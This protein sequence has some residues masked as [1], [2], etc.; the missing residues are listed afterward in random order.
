MWLVVLTSYVT[1]VFSLVAIAVMDG[2]KVTWSKWDRKDFIYCR[3]RGDISLNLLTEKNL[4]IPQSA[5][6]DTGEDYFPATSIQTKKAWILYVF[7]IS[8]AIYNIFHTRKFNKLHKGLLHIHV[9]YHT[10]CN[11]SSISIILILFP[12]IQPRWRWWHY[13]VLNK[14]I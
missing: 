4:W 7:K 12:M 9:T 11:P 1:A 6:M 2:S 10:F 3:S 14:N 13:V 8:C 5:L